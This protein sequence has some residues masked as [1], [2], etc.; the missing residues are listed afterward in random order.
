MMTAL[1]MKTGRQRLS[2]LKNEIA[3]LLLIKP[4]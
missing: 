4:A 1:K 3:D 2:Q